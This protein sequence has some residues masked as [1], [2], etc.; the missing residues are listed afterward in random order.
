[1]GHGR[2]ESQELNAQ[3]RRWN[4]GDF[5][6]SP[7]EDQR[8]RWKKNMGPAPAGPAIPLRTGP[9]ESGAKITENVDHKPDAARYVV[10]DKGVYRPVGLKVTAP[11]ERAVTRIGIY[12]ST[13][14]VDGFYVAVINEDPAQGNER[15]AMKIAFE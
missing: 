6:G 13:P 9:M 1:L 3:P 8:S 12:T 2:T 7:E 11:Q 4:Q 10:V 15:S 14:P 5:R